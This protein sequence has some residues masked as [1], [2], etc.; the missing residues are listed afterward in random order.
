MAITDLIRNPRRVWKRGDPFSEF[1]EMVRDL[2]RLS[3][4]IFSGD[5]VPSPV[6]TAAGDWIPLVETYMKGDNLMFKCELPGVDPKDVDVTF[7]EGT[8]ELVIKGERKQDTRNE[9]FIYRELPYGKFE[10]RFTLRPGVKLDQM[11]AKY[12]NGMLEIT[13][14]AGAAAKPKKIQ[15]ETAKPAEG[16]A[17][18]KKAA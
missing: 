1:R 12:T 2:D 15:I 13:V 18:V 6:V 9:D 8:N 14:P 3:S 7:D 10:R 17:A 16:E 4:Q 5:I 11:K